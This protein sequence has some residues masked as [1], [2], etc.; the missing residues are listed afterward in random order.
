MFLLLF[1]GFCITIAAGCSLLSC[2]DGRHDH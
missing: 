2:L 1:I